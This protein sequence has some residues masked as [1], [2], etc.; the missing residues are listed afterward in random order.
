MRKNGK[1]LLSLILTWL[2]IV[3]AIAGNITG[4]TVEA[5]NASVTSSAVATEAQLQDEVQDGVTLQCWNWSYNNITSNMEQIAKSGF[6]AIQTSPIQTAKEGTKGKSVGTNWW[7]YYQPAAFEID[8]TGNSALGTKQDFETMC[9]AAHFYGVKVIVDVIANHMGNQTGNNLATTIT[10][11]I[12]NDS[13]CW[14]DITTNI[15]NYS[16]RYNITQYCMDGVPDLNT[17]SKKVQNYVLGFLKECIASGADGFRFDAAKHIET[18]QD[19]ASGCGSDFW[20]TVINGA[21]SYA[22]TTRG[23]DLYCYGEIL[24]GTDNNNSLSISAYT[25]YMSVTDNQTGNNLRNYV[26]SGNASGAGISSYCKSTTAS[27]IVLWAESHDTYANNQSSGVSTYNIDKTWALVAARADAMGLYFA[28]PNSTSTM[29]GSADTAGWSYDEVGTANRFHNAF[30]GQTEYMSSEGNIAYC[31]RGTSGAVLVNCSGSSAYISV[32]AHKMADG[33]YK[34]QVSGNEFVVSNGK[35]SGTIGEKGF[36]VVYNITE[37]VKNPTVSISQEGGTFSSDTLSLTVTLNNAESGTYQIGDDTAVTYT[38]SENFTIGSDMNVGDKKTIYL[39]A[40]NGTTVKEAT[41]TFEKVEQSNNIAYLQLPSGW[42]SEVYCY[43][44]DS[45]TEQVKNAAWP[46]EKMKE[47]EDGLYMY[48][49][50]ESIEAPKVIFYNS[51]TNRYPADMQPGLLLSGSMIYTD[52]TWSN[53]TIETYGTV[54]ACYTDEDGNTL[55]E[56]VSTTGVIGTSYSTSEKTIAGYTLQNV[57]GNESGTYTT[58]NITVTYVYKET[59]ITVSN[60]AYIEKP[61][62]WTGAMYCYV[63]SEDNESNC[64]AAW[65]GVAMTSVS[66]SL[67]KYEVSAAISNPLVIFTDETNQYPA[68]M[69][70]GLSLTGSMIYQNGTWSSYTE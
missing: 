22:E 32:T 12:R 8:D 53:Y 56:A 68:S 24:D 67:Y 70:K 44:Y 66:G 48:E 45:A 37:P 4:L 5:A 69:Q 54:T 16:S 9:E 10:P 41:Y 3:S 63:Y 31:E 14:H 60:T 39:T 35:I 36:A 64:N 47:I 58:D 19:S 42:G 59:P 26:N 21:K 49:V 13:S 20:S 34:D 17:S 29:L 27:N 25:Q 33:T 62:N 28:R 15:S 43:A 30:V 51:A 50:S 23:I 61:S 6:S 65:P 11:D 7:V 52:G 38:G 2:V 57:Q 46:G 55:A 18:S 1:K 40:I